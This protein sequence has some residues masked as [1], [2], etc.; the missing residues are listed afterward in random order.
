M[1]EFF[2]SGIRDDYK[3]AYN[4]KPRCAPGTLSRR[5]LY[6]LV[7][8]ATRLK[9]ATSGVTEH[10]SPSDT[11]SLLELQQVQAIYIP[12]DL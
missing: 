8:G 7:A 9:L 6:V 4:K 12:I 5:N 10:S 1:A 11:R 3:M 2:R